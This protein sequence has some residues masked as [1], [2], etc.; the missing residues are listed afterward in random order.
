MN[1]FTSNLM[2]R[3]NAKAS[4]VSIGPGDS[5]QLVP[6]PQILEHSEFLF[7]R[8]EVSLFPVDSAQRVMWLWVSGIQPGRLLQFRDGF[9]V[10]F[11]PLEHLSQTQM[12]YRK[13]RVD[14]ERI[15]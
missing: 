6:V 2:L 11:F 10:S 9:L 8:F 15:A 5:L 14:A 13:T 7:H 12:G 4:Q 1:R 3:H